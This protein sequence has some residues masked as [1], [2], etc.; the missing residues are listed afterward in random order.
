M[1][2]STRSGHVGH[3]RAARSPELMVEPDTCRQAEKALSDPLAQA[4]AGEEDRL[5]ALA[6]RGQVGPVPGL[7]TPG[8]PHDRGAQ[9]ADRRRESAP[10]IAL[11]AQEDLPARALQ[12]PQQL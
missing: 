7:I 8:G 12:A 3:E 4:L 6:D 10:G 1:V 2:D 11:V 5:D 9:L